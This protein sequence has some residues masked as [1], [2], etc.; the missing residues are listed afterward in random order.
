MLSIRT[1][2]LHRSRRSDGGFM[3]F[4]GA[5]GFEYSHFITIRDGTAG[6]A[7]DKKR[8]RERE[9]VDCKLE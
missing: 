4:Y 8:V 2:K 6:G 3:L 9:R 7:I 1:V 5:A